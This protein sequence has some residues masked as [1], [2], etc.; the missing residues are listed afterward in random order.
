MKNTRSFLLRKIIPIS[1]VLLLA[2]LWATPTFAASAHACSAAGGTWDGP[3]AEN[4]KCIYPAGSATAVAACGTSQLSYTTFFEN[5]VQVSTLCGG[6]GTTRSSDGPSDESFTLKLG[7][8]KNGWVTFFD[9][10]CRHNCTIDSVLPGLAKA[11]IWTTPLATLYV[12]VDGGAGADGYQVCFNNP[13]GNLWTIY[14]FFGGVWDVAARST[15]SIV[16]ATASGDGAFFL[17]GKP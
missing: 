3:D 12:R 15:G 9:K 11:E 10:S 2:L 8:G 6:R 17:G 4:G 16:C 14:Q 13:S 1:L 7:H 5:D